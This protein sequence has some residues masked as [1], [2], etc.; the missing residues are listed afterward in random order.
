MTGANSRDADRLRVMS[1]QHEGSTDSLFAAMPPLEAK[2]ALFAF[3]AGCVRE[4][5]KE[6][7]PK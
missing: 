4:D 1:I 5:D 3:I 2:E 6:D 7:M